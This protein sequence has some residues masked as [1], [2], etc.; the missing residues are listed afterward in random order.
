VYSLGVLL[1]SGSSDNSVRIWD[2]ETHEC[3]H[4]LE[5]HSDEVTCVKIKVQLCM[6]MCMSWLACLQ[7]ILFYLKNSGLVEQTTLFYLK[8]W[9]GCFRIC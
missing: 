2:L 1:V 9:S 8:G 7:T 6:S 5:N 3:S 4:V